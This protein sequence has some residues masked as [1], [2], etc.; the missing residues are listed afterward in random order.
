[1]SS[2]KKF[3]D[4]AGTSFLWNQITT[5][6]NKKA[7]IADLAAVATSGAAADITLTDTGNYFTASTVEGALQEIGSSLETT[8]AVTVT[9]TAGSGSVLKVYT[10]SQRG[11]T[12]GTI[13]IP[14]DLVATSGEI[15]NSDGTNS[16]TFL[17]LTIAN[18]SPIYINVASLIE[19]NGVTD[20]AEIDFTDTNHQISGTL[21]VGSIAK[22][23]L[24][25]SVQASLGLADSAL[26]PGDITEGS[27][28]GTILVNGTAVAVHGLGTAAYTA[29]TAYDAS[30]EA[31]AAYDAISALTNTE[32]NAAIAAANTPSE[33]QEG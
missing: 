26:Q 23:K 14:K 13:N 16:G 31:Q 5:E 33:P 22:T 30:G 15:V 20:S 1:M 4:A 32:I 21:K 25:S 9:E 29:S 19:Y 3:L 18:G 2:I 17:K 24:D 7:A 10:L 28:N 8:G 11:S 12:I 6:L 27:T